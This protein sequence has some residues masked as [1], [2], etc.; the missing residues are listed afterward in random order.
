MAKKKP[1]Q[2]PTA[3]TPEA[4]E[5]FC[6]IV[7]PISDIIPYPPGHWADVRGILDAAI[8]KAGFTPKLV[9][10]AEDATIIQGTIIENLY[11][12]EIIVCDIS[13]QNANVML[14]LGIRLAVKK[15]VV[16][17]NDKQITPPFDITTI[18]YCPYPSDLRHPTVAKFID[19]L[20][21]AIKNT[22][23]ASQKPDYRTFMDYFGKMTV[24]GLGVEEV[25]WKEY[26]ETMFRDLGRKIDRT[27]HDAKGES[28]NQ[29][30]GPSYRAVNKIN[31]ILDLMPE[32]TIQDLRKLTFTT[33]TSFCL[34]L[35]DRIGDRQIRELNQEQLYS[36]ICQELSRLR[37]RFSSSSSSSS[38]GV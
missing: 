12:N 27:G 21:K 35:V 13:A 38:S 1:A 7:M 23:E 18:K 25:Q 14:E 30:K 33:P 22:Y 36:V 5:R 28:R 26:M 24:P 16:I 3:E 2:E 32:E 31:H 9:S 11:E 8:K 4:D 15:P 34:H 29:E 6:G 19:D 10:E 17:V 37:K 20:C